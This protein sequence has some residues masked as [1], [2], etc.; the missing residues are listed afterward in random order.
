MQPFR[1]GPN[2]PPRFYRGGESIARFR[3][4]PHLRDDVPEDWVGSTTTILGEPQAGLTRLP[5]GRLLRD[6]VVS[7]PEGWLGEAHARRHGADPLLLVKLL[8]AAE[9]LPVHCH[10]GD[11]FARRHLGCPCG[12]T[13]AWVVLEAQPDAAVHLG[14]RQDV[15]AAP[16]AGWVERQEAGALLDSLNR[17]PVAPGDAVLVPAGVPHAI[18][19]G[20]FVVELQQAADLNVLLEWTG[21]DVDGMR[22]GHLGLGFERALSCVDRSGW[23]HERLR[24]LLRDRSASRGASSGVALALPPR[25]DAF[26][27]VERVEPDP[28]ARCA[29]SF[30][31][32]VVVDGEGM[33]HTQRGAALPL[34]RGDTLLV[35][36]AAG[37]LEVHGG[38]HALR[39]L[40]PATVDR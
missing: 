22:D 35:P 12:K 31:V 1:M 39:C 11:D 32:L 40:P 24:T 18:G 16:L 17:I 10:P 4:L 21:F 9:R 3:G 23:T 7:D 34:A 29:A 26:F 13:E 36:F 25:A 20:V 19:A 38:V 15:G 33:L 2:Q 28:A 37:D 8:D 30:A 14:F 6:A 5:D 27:R